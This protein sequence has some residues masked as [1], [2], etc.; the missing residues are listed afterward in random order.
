LRFMLNYYCLCVYSPPSMPSHCHLV[1]ALVAVLS[2]EA[3][4]P[5]LASDNQPISIASAPGGANSRIKELA[6]AYNLHSRKRNAI[7]TKLEACWK[8]EREISGERDRRGRAGDM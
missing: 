7:A 3:L 2:L 1:L 5:V 4:L 8:E 6:V